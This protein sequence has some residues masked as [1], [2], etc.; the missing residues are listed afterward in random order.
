MARWRLIVALVVV[1]Q[2]AILQLTVA[3]PNS[4]LTDLLANHGDEIH[5]RELQSTAA[6]AA[7]LRKLQSAVGGAAKQSQGLLLG[8]L[9]QAKALLTASKL[10]LTEEQSRMSAQVVDDCMSRVRKNGLPANGK[11]R[12]Q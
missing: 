1:C 3:N 11:M 5:H 10:G 7:Q 12:A 2:I 8:L 4:A 9:G 6:S